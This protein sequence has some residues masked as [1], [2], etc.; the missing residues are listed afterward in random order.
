M[1]HSRQILTWLAISVALAAAGDFLLRAPWG[2]NIAVWLIVLLGGYVMLAL[3]RT[4]T[5]TK[6]LAPL[7]ALA[8][9]F[10]VMAAWR[11]L[12][13]LKA[14]DLGIAFAAMILATAPHWHM[15]L[16]H[17]PL[18]RWATLGAWQILRGAQFPLKGATVASSVVNGRGRVST[19]LL[20]SC[21][22]GVIIAIPLVGVFVALFMQA[23]ALYQRF[24]LDLVEVDPA[25]V[26]RHTV[27]TVG[28][29]WFGSAA[30]YFW[31]AGTRPP[32]LQERLGDGP[33]WLV[34]ITVVLAVIDALFISFV[35]IQVRYFFGGHERVLTETGL[36]Y[37][38]YARRGFFELAAVSA[39]SL[40]MLLGMDWVVNGARGTGRRL[41]DVLFVLHIVLVLVVAAS[42]LHRMAL[43]VDAYGLT[44]LRICVSAFVVW[45]IACFLWCGVT[46]V[47]RR[48]EW[49]PL[50]A[51]CAGV[52]GA[53]ALHSVNPE[54]LAMRV[55]LE[56][57][58]D[59]KGF[60]AEYATT[61]GADAAPALAA[62]WK[63]LSG[64]DR[65]V[66]R[67]S[68]QSEYETLRASD[69]RSWT[70]SRERAMRV[71]KRWT[72]READATDE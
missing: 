30:I 19:E 63:D 31:V 40:G 52:I 33:K 20:Q 65:R 71:L 12:P 28:T 35:V 14:V 32:Q 51:F 26:M 18:E 49:F 41:F 34:E 69:W 8:G 57:M 4:A 24:V 60:D 61:L 16:R 54:G 38:S 3:Q 7:L 11:D 58:R 29:L 68:L 13:A 10:A 70:L 46:F 66:V 1:E 43:Y 45:L 64:D 47:A 39:T 5:D 72:E 42:A 53:L 36:T 6:P 2:L 22:R 21:V 62:A 44:V 23:D 17:S 55:D 56:R 15:A 27:A 50:G 59:G 67:A 37:A 48:R 9:V 25:V